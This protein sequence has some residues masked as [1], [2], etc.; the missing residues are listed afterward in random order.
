MREQDTRKYYGFSKLRKSELIDFM[1]RADSAS[2][3]PITQMPIQMSRPR[4]PYNLSDVSHIFET[5]DEHEER[6]QSYYEPKPEDSVIEDLICSLQ[7]KYSNSSVTFDK[8][9]DEN[10]DLI[11]RGNKGKYIK[12][13]GH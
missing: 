7:S 6:I 9:D 2:G 11:Y 4:Q 3:N 5:P 10:N 1:Y 12:Q 8:N 13:H